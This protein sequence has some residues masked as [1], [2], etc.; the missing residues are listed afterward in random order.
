MKKI[1]SLV[2]TLSFCCLLLISCSP[3]STPV[4]DDSTLDI[5]PDTLILTQDDSTKLV[6]LALSCGC[7]FTVEVTGI[8]G[9]TNTIKY[10]PIGPLEETLTKRSIRFTYSPSSAIPGLHAVKLDF[11]AKKKTFSYTNSVVVEAR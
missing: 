1:V 10:M 7:G 6:E 9:D 4:T 5:T 8:T 2:A 11:L 3:E